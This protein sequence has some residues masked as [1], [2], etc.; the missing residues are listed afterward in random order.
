MTN[1]SRP[2]DFTSSFLF[3]RPQQQTIMLRRLSSLI[4]Q[5]APSTTEHYPLTTTATSSSS[6]GGNRTRTSES[7]M[8]PDFYSS[9]TANMM[10]YRNF[11][12][13][14]Q[15]ALMPIYFDSNEDFIR[16]VAMNYYYSQHGDKY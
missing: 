2:N 16:R 5:L 13:R 12:N 14:R 4:Q 8:P 15:Q 10:Q 3:P 9:R 1:H 6:L 7:Y 11:V